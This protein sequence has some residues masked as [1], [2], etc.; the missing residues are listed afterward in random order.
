MIFRTTV[1]N[2]DK[3]NEFQQ[4]GDVRKHHLFLNKLSFYFFTTPVLIAASLTD[5]ATHT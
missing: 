5:L 4:K 2:F 3:N 1:L